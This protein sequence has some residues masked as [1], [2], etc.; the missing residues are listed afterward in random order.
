MTLAHSLFQFALVAGLLTLTPGIDV[1]L[2][3]RQSLTQTRP[4]AVLTGLGI[5]TGCLVWG[6]AAAVGVSALVT[7]SA[8]AFRVVKLAGAV[9]LLWMGVQML[10]AAVRGGDSSHGETAGSVRR[11]P[12]EAFTKGVFTNLLNPKIGVFYVAVL[13]QFLPPG[14]SAALVGAMLAA[15]HFAE[16]I[17]WFA[18]LVLAAG[19][20]RHL[21]DG[22]RASRVIDAVTGTVLVLFGG[23]LLLGGLHS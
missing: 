10:R 19:R 2:V 14:H 6:M 5:G 20:M 16:S 12:A 17:C 15:I 21:L 22:P 18:V 11:R 8:L 9:Y 13:P 1:A 3:L 7:A 23:H 4:V